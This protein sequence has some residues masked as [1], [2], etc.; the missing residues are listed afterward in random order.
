M[1]EAAATTGAPLIAAGVR[2]GD[3]GVVHASDASTVG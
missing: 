3:A 1:I 2:K